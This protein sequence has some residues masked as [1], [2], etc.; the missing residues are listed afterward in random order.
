MG[1][2]KLSPWGRSQDLLS[3]ETKHDSSSNGADRVSV[4]FSWVLFSTSLHKGYV[5]Q[6]LV[7]SCTK[8]YIS[9]N[10]AVHCFHSERCFFICN[11][12]DCISSLG[13]GGSCLTNTRGQEVV[14]SG[15]PWSG[16]L[17]PVHLLYMQYVATEQLFSRSHREQQ[18]GPQE[19]KGTK[20]YQ[21]LV[22]GDVFTLGWKILSV[23]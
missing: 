7:L 18:V 15:M 2:L 13:F 9:Q 6:K 12:N 3:M 16:I 8:L 22:N 19:N 20:R 5:L 11:T 21:E 4:V 10:S 23:L 1:A 17:G 14:A